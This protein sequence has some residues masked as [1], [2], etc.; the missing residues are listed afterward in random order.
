MARFRM[1]SVCGC[2][3]CDHINLHFESPLRWL[4]LSLSPSLSVHLPS[5]R[6]IS[7]PPPSLFCLH[8]AIGFVARFLLKPLRIVFKSVRGSLLFRRFYSS[9]LLLSAAVVTSLPL[10]RSLS[11][12]R[13]SCKIL[14][15]RP[16]N[17]PSCGAS[18]CRH[19][20]RIV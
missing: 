6:S 17:H 13:R 15:F 5:P 9:L 19:G 12:I 3:V 4:S 18:S 14:R 20:C 7:L 1:R 10:A 8:L 11:F 2:I 16:T